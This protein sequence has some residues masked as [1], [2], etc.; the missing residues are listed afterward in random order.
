MKPGAKSSEERSPKTL[1]GI[2]RVPIK[3]NGGISDIYREVKIIR[4]WVVF[5]GIAAIIGLVVAVF[6]VAGIL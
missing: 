2:P 3:E 5:I 6:A 1:M 4:R